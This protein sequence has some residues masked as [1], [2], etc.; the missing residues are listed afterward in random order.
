[1]QLAVIT[2]DIVH[3]RKANE[4]ELW[5]GRLKTLLNQLTPRASEWEIYRGDSFQFMVK[6]PKH[7]LRF[8]LILRAGILALK[9]LHELK[10]DVRLAIGVGE[11][12][13]KGDTI[14]ESTGSAYTNSGEMLDRI[15]KEGRRL[16]FHSNNNAINNELH[17]SLFLAD[18]LIRCW[19]HAAA[20]IAWMYFAHPATQVEYARKLGIS[21]PAVHKRM[22]SA[23]IEEFECLLNRYAY[24][25]TQFSS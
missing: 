13:Y 3:S 19:S 6:E 8:A 14:S 18:A 21:Q 24:L 16:A 17:T 2:G 15:S 7:A 4:P 23:H 5:Q 10:L 1:M 12:K 11:Q 22:M 9:P 20:E 25:A